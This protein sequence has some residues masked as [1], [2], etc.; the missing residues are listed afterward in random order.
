MMLFLSP[1]NSGPGHTLATRS[2]TAFGGKTSY[3]KE[4]DTKAILRTWGAVVS[5]T[6]KCFNQHRL[7]I[8]R[9]MDFR[10]HF[11]MGVALSVIAQRKQIHVYSIL[12]W[13]DI[14][15]ACKS[16]PEKSMIF[17]SSLVLGCYTR[18]SKAGGIIRP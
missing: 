18:I 9:T 2:E 14:S 7:E 11:S 17:S 13:V 12:V 15:L 10:P 5:Q 3:S 1:L 16:K 8:T 6:E 4:P